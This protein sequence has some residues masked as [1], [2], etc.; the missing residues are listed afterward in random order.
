MAAHWSFHS[1]LLQLSNPITLICPQFG[2]TRAVAIGMHLSEETIESMKAGYQQTIARL[3]Q[4][5]AER[6]LESANAT[7]QISFYRA[8]IELLDELLGVET[9][10][11]NDTP[12]ITLS[13]PVPSLPKGAGPAAAVKWAVE[14]FGGHMGMTS[15]EIRR[16]ILT[17]GYTRPTDNFSISV[18][19]TLKR[20]TGKI[21]ECDSSS[22]V[23]RYRL[24]HSE[25]SPNPTE[26]QPA[27][28]ARDA[29]DLSGGA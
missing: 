2:H 17:N 27:Q 15:A 8:K 22:G 23:R 3:K 11:G 19:K 20:L 9:T 21:L 25:F 14:H 29:A 1:N 26:P 13:E 7:Q 4:Q 28:P 18:A 10:N 24:R 6:D 12:T 16:K 5:N